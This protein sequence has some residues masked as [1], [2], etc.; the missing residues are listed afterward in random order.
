MTHPIAEKI[1]IPVYLFDVGD[2][3]GERRRKMGTR[4]YVRVLGRNFQ[5]MIRTEK[6]ARRMEREDGYNW[7]RRE[8]VL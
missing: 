4:L 3:S 6:E 8:S 2:F 5:I 7:H 1:Q